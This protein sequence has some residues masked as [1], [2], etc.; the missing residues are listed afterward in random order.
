MIVTSCTTTVSPGFD[1][2]Q[3]PPV[4]AAQS[5]I[6]EPARIAVTM[7]AVIRRGAGLPG[8]C[9]VVTTRSTSLM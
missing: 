1:S 9:A 6:T 4:S 2:S 8:I 5:T 7:S 3:L